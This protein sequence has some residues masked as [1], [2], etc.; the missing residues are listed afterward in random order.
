MA[1]TFGALMSIEARGKFGNAI[2]FRMQNGQ[3]IAS[4]Y[5]PTNASKS[6]AQLA[7]RKIFLDGTD[8]WATLTVEEKAVW[9]ADAKIS[10]ISGFSLF[11]QDFLRKGGL[12]PS[13]TFHAY[14][15]LSSYYVDVITGISDD[16]NA[17]CGWFQ[18]QSSARP[19]FWGIGGTRQEIETQ[20]YGYV[21]C[22]GISA[23]GEV[24]ALD[25]Y[26][27]AYFPYSGYYS[28]ASGLVVAPKPT[29]ANFTFG[30]MIAKN[31]IVICALVYYPSSTNV[32]VWDDASGWTIAQLPQGDSV[33]QLCSISGD[34]SKVLA[35]IDTLVMGNAVSVLRIFDKTA[36]WEDLGI[37]A[38][39]TLLQAAKMS[40]N[41]NVIYAAIY[42]NYVAM[43]LIWD[44]SAGWNL[45]QLPTNWTQTNINE[46]SGNG[47]FAAVGAVI[48]GKYE[49]ARISKQ[50]IGE[51]VTPN[52]NSIMAMAV[53]ISSNGKIAAVDTNSSG[54]RYP[55]KVVFP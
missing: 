11:M 17:A 4:K 20:G 8:V 15:G 18:T 9:R 30:A 50:G 38:D 34:G 54:Q 5:V 3:Q 41:A 52:Q 37:A 39:V 42:S 16:G 46:V 55:F 25:L 47:E 2:T 24:V 44:R 48:A 13:P 14:A 6:S 26:D 29:G 12:P 35:I 22:T 43:L 36:G 1:K 33:N 27:D 51:V 45:I 19:I 10:G 53:G 31:A 32:G 23:N 49:A 28:V 7:H 21:T 40:R